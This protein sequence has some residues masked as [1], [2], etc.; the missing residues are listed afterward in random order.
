MG[1]VFASGLSLPDRHYY[2]TD[3]Q[4]ALCL[5]AQSAFG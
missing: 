5:L 3:D 1:A 4:E 2:F